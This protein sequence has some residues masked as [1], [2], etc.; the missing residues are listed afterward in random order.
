MFWDAWDNIFDRSKLTQTIFLDLVWIF[1]FESC[2]YN[3]PYYVNWIINHLNLVKFFPH[4][5]LLFNFENCTELTWAWACT[6]ALP[7][8]PHINLLHQK[9]FS[10]QFMF[11][12]Y[13]VCQSC[14]SLLPRRLPQEWI[15]SYHS[16]D[17]KHLF[18]F[19]LWI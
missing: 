6:F 11:S 2:K 3:V 10:L 4:I 7:I 9:Y 19:T 18:M 17:S 8:L 1:W 13:S 12:E 15:Q 16:S 14:F 5:I